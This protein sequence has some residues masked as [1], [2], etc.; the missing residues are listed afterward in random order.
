[1]ILRPDFITLLGGIAAAWPLTA[2]AQQS[3]EGRRIAV[4]IALPEGDPELEARVLVPTSSPMSTGDR[5]RD[6][7]R[8]SWFAPPNVPAS[9]WP[10]ATDCHAPKDGTPGRR[11]LPPA[12]PA[13]PKL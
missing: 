3:G 5:D 2:R 1:M 6:R 9:V 7:A 12:E 10:C 4:M 8:A 13:D 11:R